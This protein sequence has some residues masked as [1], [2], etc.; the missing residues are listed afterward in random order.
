MISHL[1][2]RFIAGYIILALSA[3]T[4]AET[5]TSP[6]LSLFANVLIW[7]LREGSA[8]NWAQIFTPKGS[9]QSVTVVNVP[10]TWNPGLRF[11]GSYEAADTPWKVSLYNTIYHTTGANQASGE[12]YSAFLGNFY[13]GN[14]NGLKFGPYYDHGSIRWVFKYDTIDF[15][16]ARLF[17]INSTFNLSPFIGVKT[18]FINQSMF[19]NWENPHSPNTP[20]TPY[21]F[22][23]ASEDL[24]NNFFGIGPSVGANSLWLFYSDDTSSF[25]VQAMISAALLYGHWTFKDVYANNENTTINVQS[26]PITSAATMT[27]GKLGLTWS[28]Q[29]HSMTLTTSLNYEA[30]LWF[31]QMRY[32]SYNMGRLDNLLSLQGGDIDVSLGF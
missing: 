15:E 26:S 23:S 32:Y 7:K 4:Y 30:Q 22:T 21:T 28:H 17:K 25:G 14:T 1:K 6:H 18:A 24:Q 20:P 12:V 3:P 19:S 16:L 10:F 27:S 11:G 9:Y 2:N 31:N 8:D 29:M 5:N 13:V